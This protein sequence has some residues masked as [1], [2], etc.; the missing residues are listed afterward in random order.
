MHV[1]ANLALKPQFRPN[2]AEP[3]P[4]MHGLRRERSDVIVLA[5]VVKFASILVIICENGAII[6]SAPEVEL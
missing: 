1:C 6:I 2:L 3:D 5:T 4:Y